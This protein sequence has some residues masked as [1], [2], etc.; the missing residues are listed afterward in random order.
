MPTATN[1]QI[2]AIPRPKQVF[3][4]IA[5]ITPETLFIFDFKANRAL[6]YFERERLTNQHPELIRYMTDSN[7]KEWLIQQRL[8]SPTH[9][10][11][12]ILLLVLD[13]V[14]KVSQSEECRKRTNLRLNELTGFKV[15][16]SMQNK[17]KIFFNELSQKSKTLA[18]SSTSYV[19]ANGSITI[20]ALASA[21]NLSNA[22]TT[23]QPIEV[24]NQIKIDF[25]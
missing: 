2:N 9:R 15:P 24:K 20:P 1:F 7:D 11:F 10:N 17:M 18:A 12:R 23:L 4:N 22:I 16:E 25:L 5:A 6:G 21:T 14:V 19:F 13:E 3:W 8:L